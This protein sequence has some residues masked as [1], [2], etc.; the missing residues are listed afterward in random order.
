MYYDTDEKTLVLY[1]NSADMEIA[2]GERE[3][4]RCRNNTGATIPKGTAVYVNG[5]H[6][7][8]HPVHGHHPTVAPADAADGTKINVIGITA[9]DILTS[10][11]GYVVCRGYIHN[12]D[13]SM[14]M[15]GMTAYLCP[16]EP[17]LWC[18][19]APD[20]PHFPVE[21]GICL[22][23][24]ATVG[25]LYV[26]I[27]SK[28]ADRLRVIGSEYV[29]GDLTVGGNLTVV[30]AENRLVV[31]N[32]EVQ[33]QYVYLGAGDSVSTTFT[34]SGLNDMGFKGHYTG[35]TTKTFYVKIDSVGTA[36]TFAWSLDNFTTT[37]ASAIAITGDSQLLQDGVSVDFVSV[38]GHTLNDKWSG[39]GAP[40][41]KDIAVIG[42]Y[43]ADG[44]YTHAGMF[45]DARLSSTSLCGCPYILFKPADM[46][47]TWGDTAFRYSVLD[48]VRDP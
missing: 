46:I 3:W 45:R 39:V 11:H 34:G 19:D 47:A 7:A 20:Y 30:G 36:D 22:T 28:V 35:V 2:L 9:Q 16:D 42:N 5:V 12:V 1:G 38:M 6:I 24:D 10:N 14:L 15:N 31:N 41:N 18:M 29:D 43:V 33:N 27:S 17:G 23:S 48:E 44:V 40:R 13:T 32:L 25:T 8:G 26:N 4:V 21:L 37:E